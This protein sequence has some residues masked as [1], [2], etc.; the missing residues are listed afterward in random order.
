MHKKKK[1]K[2]FFNI[3]INRGW[4]AIS[5]LG[6][7]VIWNLD[8]GFWNP[9]KFGFG[10]FWSLKSGFWILKLNFGFDFLKFR[11]WILV[12]L[13]IGFGISSRLKFGFGISGPPLTHPI[14]PCESVSLRN[15]SFLWNIYWKVGKVP[16]TLWIITLH[17]LPFSFIFMTKG[18][19]IFQKMMRTYI[20]KFIVISEEA[21]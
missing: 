2:E 11:F 13:K 1:T 5:D 19:F 8:L 20:L 9:W 6:F 10:I 7:F 18:C 4:K 17:F 21:S 16:D 3:Y 12:C 14:N 15:R